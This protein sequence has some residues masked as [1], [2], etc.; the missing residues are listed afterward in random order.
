[1]KQT[2]SM[3]WFEGNFNTKELDGFWICYGTCNG[4]DYSFKSDTEENAKLLA[5]AYLKKHGH[6]YDDTIN[7]INA[8]KD[9]I[10]RNEERYNNIYRQSLERTKSKIMSVYYL[11][12]AVSKTGTHREKETVIMYMKVVLENLINKGDTLPLEEDYLPF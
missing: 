11:L 1:M 8:L 4:Y 10:K 12:D 9:E 3:F 2:Y 5:S 6:L 7:T